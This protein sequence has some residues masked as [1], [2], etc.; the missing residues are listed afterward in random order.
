MLTEED[1]NDASDALI[2]WFKYQDIKPVDGTMIMLKLI[3]TQLV[4]KSRELER[5]S[6]AM[7][8]ISTLLSIEI[9]SELRS[10]PK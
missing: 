10:K 7:R 9:A 5:L 1:Y 3:A 8:N 4:A 6:E 2:E